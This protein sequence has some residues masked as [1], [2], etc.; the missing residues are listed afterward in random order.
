V[1]D[2]PWR[3]PRSISPKCTQ[4]CVPRRKRGRK[5]ECHAI[6]A[7]VA[8]A[9]GKLKLEW[10]Q[11]GCALTLADT[12]IAAVALEQGCP[13]LTDNRKDFPMPQLHLYD[14]PEE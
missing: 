4:E 2:T 6:T 10:K 13:L 8:E 12:L 5:L 3:L 14:L 1:E 7:S 11:K 9:A